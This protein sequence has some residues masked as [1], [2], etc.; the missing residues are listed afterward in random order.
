MKRGALI[1]AI[2]AIIGSATPVA[3][4]EPFWDAVRAGNVRAVK[5]LLSAC[6]ENNMPSSDDAKNCRTGS[7]HV[8]LW[9]ST[10][11]TKTATRRCM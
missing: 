11:R 1:V 4:A 3:G 6:T 10:L 8:S 2:A 7:L 9:M 5:A